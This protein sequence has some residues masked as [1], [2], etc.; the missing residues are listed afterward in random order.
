MPR[1]IHS[2]EELRRLCRRR[3]PRV[4][5]D[6]IEAG[7]DD[8]HCVSRNRTAFASYRIKGRHLVDVRERSQKTT[9]FGRTF[10]S[11]FGIA[12]MG[13]ASVFRRG[14]EAHMAEAARSENIPFCASGTTMVSIEDLAKG[15]TDRLWLQIYG[16]HDTAITDDMVRR[17]GDLGIETLLLTVDLPV[18][19][20]RETDLRNGFAL[21]PKISFRNMSE[22][23]LHPLWL[24]EYLRHGLPRSENW[25]RYAPAGADARAIFDFIYTQHPANQTWADLARIR[26]LW[27]GNLVVK[28][29]LHPEDAVRCAEMGADGVLISNHGGKALDKAPSSIEVLPLVA[30]AVGGRITIMVD[31]GFRRGSDMIVAKCLGADFILVGRPA[32][33]G[34]VADRVRGARA[35][36][37]ILR[38]E[39]DLTLALMGCPNFDAL[40][41]EFV[42]HAG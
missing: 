40:G 9:I 6:A 31:S 14:V 2:I 19:P 11:P 42:H 5:V 34:A 3:L 13:I 32:L 35:A 17:A 20:N 26:S 41:P 16:A 25:A 12:P 38:R 10:D 29:I 36:I 28:G 39:I 33:Y 7:V 23:L 37:G 15:G 8:D 1:D 4:L 22:A 27:K 21:P 24:A 30:D 18:T